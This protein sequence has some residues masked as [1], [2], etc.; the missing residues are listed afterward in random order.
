MF[1]NLVILI[2]T[3]VLI[4]SCRF[5]HIY[6]TWGTKSLVVANGCLKQVMTLSFCGLGISCKPGKDLI[7]AFSI[8]NVVRKHAATCL[9]TFDSVCKQL[10][11]L[12][13]CLSGFCY[14]LAA[15]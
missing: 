12:P 5:W 7:L 14:E 2:T 6:L 3:F 8:F 4:S 9:L 13:C 10:M 1:I 15:I 11:V